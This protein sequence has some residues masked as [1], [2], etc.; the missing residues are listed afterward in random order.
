MADE[1][2]QAGL[3]PE[4]LAAAKEQLLKSGDLLTKERNNEIVEER[5]ARDRNSRGGELTDAKA[6]LEAAQT[7]LAEMEKIGATAT[8]MQ[9]T[10]T[11]V[12][13]GM[14]A[15]L[16]TEQQGHVPKELPLGAQ[17]KFM[18]ALRAATPEPQKAANVNLGSGVRAG[19]G[20][21]EKEAPETRAR[22]LGIPLN[23]FKAIEG[24]S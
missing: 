22:R 19:E 18:R 11:E 20:T 1:T 21:P 12:H 9:A 6:K 15:E 17:I 24:S 16:S 7:K 2:A 14:L 10:L 8:E 13:A 5:L 23:A 3:T 4:Q